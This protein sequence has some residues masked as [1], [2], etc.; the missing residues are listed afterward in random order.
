MPPR[1]G[2]GDHIGRVKFAALYADAFPGGLAESAAFYDK[3]I[4]AAAAESKA[5]GGGTDARRA[6]RFLHDAAR[7]IWL[8]DQIDRDDI[9]NDRPAWQVHFY[10]ITAEAVAKRFF[11]FKGKGKSRHYA[12]TF[13]SDLCTNSHRAL[14][15]R[16]FEIARPTSSPWK[17]LTWAEA[18][19]LLY[20]LRCDV[21]H[22]AQYYPFLMA[23]YQGD[24]TTNFNI[25]AD[26][27]L[28]VHLT[29]DQLRQ[30]IVEGVVEAAKK[31]VP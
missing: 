31:L 17:S 3:V 7:V 10:T 16:A 22:V 8:A 26:M 27:A 12:K 30:I 15:G 29:A 20:D 19:D 25:E 1:P 4:F 28:K 5:G 9:A 18:A 21:A 6:K 13:F 11:D 14:L 24:I 2:T 23:E